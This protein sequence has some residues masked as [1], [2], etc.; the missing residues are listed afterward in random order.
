[1]LAKALAREKQQQGIG[2]KSAKTMP[3]SIEEHQSEV[4]EN[5]NEAE[6]DNEDDISTSASGM[7]IH[8]PV[9]TPGVAP[10]LVRTLTNR[11]A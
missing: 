9:I 3:A 5:E 1:M 8:I 2:N 4:A 10:I 7:K 11:I 6:I